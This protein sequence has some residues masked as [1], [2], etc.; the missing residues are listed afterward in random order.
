LIFLNIPLEE[1]DRG[2]VIREVERR[3]LVERRGKVLRRKGNDVF[4]RKG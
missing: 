1:E 4:R 2:W 3:E